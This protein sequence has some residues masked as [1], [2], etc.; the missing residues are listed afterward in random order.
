MSK[1]TVFTGAGVALITPMGPDGSVNFDKFRELIDWQI[2]NGTDAIVACGT[3]G[4][5]PALN[6]AEHLE[7][8]RVAVEQTA[9]RVP[10]VA[11]T[12]SNDT[13]HAV[14]MSR[15]A[16]ALGADALL[17]VTPYYNKT[18]QRGLVASF[19]AIADSVSTPI[20]MYNVPS[21]TGVNMKPATVAELSRHPNITGIKEASGS[22][23]AAAEIASL[24][25]IDIYSGNDD[26]IV[27]FLSVGGKGVISVLSNVA[28]RET[29]DI[30]QKW[31]DGDTAGSRDLFLK[32]L[33]LANSLFMD[34]NPIP[35][36]DAMNM[37]GLGVG[38]CRLPL[39]TMDGA[40]KE[41]LAAVLKEYKL[42]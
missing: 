18:S 31:F 22:L 15:E 30:C 23:S 38:E 2:E 34:V 41:K 33:K 10:V 17:V 1:K 29:H 26:Q 25:D 21:R 32:Y 37:M 28:P 13:A 20:I 8:L 9:G 35:V 39:V 19:T 42:I 5:N 6:D 14:M 12:G 3:T 16:E 40:S 7:L 4:E 27:P 11:G 36:K 24:C